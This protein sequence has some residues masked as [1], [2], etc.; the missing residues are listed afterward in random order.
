MGIFK[1]Y[2]E[3]QT[4]EFIKHIRL[5]KGGPTSSGHYTEVPQWL[6][7]YLITW[8]MCITESTDKEFLTAPGVSTLF[9]GNNTVYVNQCLSVSSFVHLDLVL[10]IVSVVSTSTLPRQLP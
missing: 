9:P 7:C 5:R 3:V 6:A 1:S 10:H 8:Y 4:C 2:Q